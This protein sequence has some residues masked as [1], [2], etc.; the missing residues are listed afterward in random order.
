MDDRWRDWPAELRPE[1]APV[2][3]VNSLEIAAPVDSVWRHLVLA[4]RWPE[5]YANAHD[6]WVESGPGPE[7]GL[8]T[9]FRWRTFGVPVRTRVICCEPRVALAW[10]GDEFYGRGM[11]TWLLRP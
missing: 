6:V 4:A 5:F 8:G 11:H 10:R 3:T 2:Y 7:L 1:D 9:V